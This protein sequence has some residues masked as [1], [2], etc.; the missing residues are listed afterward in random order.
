MMAVIGPRWTVR[1]GVLCLLAAGAVPGCTMVP[2][3]RIEES[4]RLTQSLRNENARLKDEVEGLQAQNR[5]LADRALDDLRRLTARGEAIER[6]QQS[7]QGYQ[8]DRDR[9]A[10]AYRRLA[11][12]LGRTTEEGAVEST[13]DWRETPAAAIPGG[14]SAS[15]SRGE[16]RSERLGSKDDGEADSSRPGSAGVGSG[17]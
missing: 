8:D 2:R 13:A 14:S 4:Q 3:E 16:R 1:L 12:S 17:P 7:V 5:D 6:L 15:V 9:L 10:A 11:A